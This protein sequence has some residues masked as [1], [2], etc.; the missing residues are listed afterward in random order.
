M[1]KIPGLKINE[2]EYELPNN[3]KGKLA[4]LMYSGNADP[5]KV[6]DY[7]VSVYVENNGYH[8]L[9]DANLD[10][11]WTRVLLSDINN[12]SQEDFDEDIHR[13]IKND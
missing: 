8:E 9:I 5:K 6:L 4:V 10:N 2:A 3:R 12:M 11:P 7:A 1:K 13:L